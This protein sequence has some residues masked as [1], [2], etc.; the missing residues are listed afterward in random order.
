MPRR[1]QTQE[2]TISVHFVPGLSF[3]VFDFGVCVVEN[4]SRT[5]AIAHSSL[6]LGL[7]L[8][9]THGEN[10][11]LFLPLSFQSRM[12]VVDT[13]QNAARVQERWL[14][15][16]ERHATAIQVQDAERHVSGITEDDAS[17]AVSVWVLPLQRHDDGVLE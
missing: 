9:Q 10:A 7:R 16:A 14:H 2:N 5:S 4:Y 6:S 8:W 1:N 11:Q 15:A 3:L 17:S 13:S 12:E